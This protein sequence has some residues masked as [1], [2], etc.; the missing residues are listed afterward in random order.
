MANEDIKDINSN[1]GGAGGDNIPASD[2]A[3]SSDNTNNNN[4]NYWAEIER[5]NA[6]NKAEILGEIDGLNNAPKIEPKVSADTEA[7]KDGD[8][9][10]QQAQKKVYDTPP[11]GRGRHK[12]DCNCEPCVIRRKIKFPN[13]DGFYVKVDSKGK[14]II[15][16]KNVLVE[17]TIDTPAVVFNALFAKYLA[18]RDNV[19]VEVKEINKVQQNYLQQLRPASSILEPSWLNYWGVFFLVTLPKIFNDKHVKWF[20]GLFKKKVKV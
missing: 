16:R 9:T 19:K 13:T 8:T 18:D 3:D 2:S 11:A 5:Q 20:F 12:I 17:N 6:S 1:A 4:T 15:E 14:P 10:K 7:P